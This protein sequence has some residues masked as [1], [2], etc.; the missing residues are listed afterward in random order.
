MKEAEL[1]H[2]QNLWNLVTGISSPHSPTAMPIM[3]VRTQHSSSKTI[4]AAVWGRSKQHWTLD[5]EVSIFIPVH[6]KHLPNL[7]SGGGENIVLSWYAEWWVH[8][9]LRDSFKHVATSTTSE[10]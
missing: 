6:A 9:P 3:L 8:Q 10:R 1:E 4:P 7:D 5:A 2:S